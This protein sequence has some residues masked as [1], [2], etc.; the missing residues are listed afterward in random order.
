VDDARATEAGVLLY[1]PPNPLGELHSLRY[2][3]HIYLQDHD[4]FNGRRPGS[5]GVPSRRVAVFHAPPTA[6]VRLASLRLTILQLRLV[7]Y[8]FEILALEPLA[9]RGAVREALDVGFAPFLIIEKHPV[10]LT[11]DPPE[12]SPDLALLLARTI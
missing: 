6:L 7:R 12:L 8:S 9:A 5:Y 11:F 3:F 4:R 10:V 1:Q 2:I